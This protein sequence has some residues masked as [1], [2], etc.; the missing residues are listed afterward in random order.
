MFIHFSIYNSMVR[1]DEAHTKKIR[2]T[3]GNCEI[4]EIGEIGE[5]D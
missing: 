3:L 5:I 4:G 2:I 1:G